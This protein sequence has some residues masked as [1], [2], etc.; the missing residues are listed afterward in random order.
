MWP[1]E[2][3]CYLLG[4]LMKE[5]L[6]T[7]SSSV[8]NDLK[9]QTPSPLY[10]PEAKVMDSDDSKE[11]LSRL[12]IIKTSPKSVKGIAPS[13]ISPSSEKPL[14]IHLVH[15]YGW[16]QKWTQMNPIYQSTEFISMNDFHSEPNWKT[17]YQSIEFISKNYYNSE[18]K[19][20][21]MYQSIE[22]I[23]NLWVTS[24]V[25]PNEK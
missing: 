11:T 18:P 7:P 8:F 24:I 1:S 16:F 9:D 15:Y 13:Y 3:I 14:S 25:N 19:W 17:M 22:F 10:L 2:V 23:L 12:R 21:T 20:Q 5:K 6:W 4:V